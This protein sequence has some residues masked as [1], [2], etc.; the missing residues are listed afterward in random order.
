MQFEL[1]IMN[2]LTSYTP[3][4][5]IPALFYKAKVTNRSQR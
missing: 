5:S 3:H 1:Q 2:T 4:I